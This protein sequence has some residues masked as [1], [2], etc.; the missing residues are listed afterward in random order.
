MS[1]FYR[2][3]RQILV[4]QK[5]RGKPEV[6]GYEEVWRN[7]QK[8]VRY[9]DEDELMSLPFDGS[10]IFDFWNSSGIEDDRLLSGIHHLKPI[11]VQVEEPVTRKFILGEEFSKL[12][13]FSTNNWNKV[14]RIFRRLPLAFKAA[15]R[16]LKDLD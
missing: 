6:S 16:E 13:Q 5:G 15:W 1:N 4:S 3:Y 12:K 7:G 8:Q 9:W 11:K 10:E 2:H 14:K